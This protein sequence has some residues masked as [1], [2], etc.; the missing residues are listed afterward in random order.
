MPTIWRLTILAFLFVPWTGCP[1][2]DDDDDDA[3]GAAPVISDVEAEVSEAVTM[4]VTVR[5]TT[6]VPSTGH[7]EF[8]VGDDLSLSTPAETGAATDHE[9]VLLGLPADADASYRVVAEADGA[10]AEGE[11]STITTGPLPPELP[12][13]T[14]TGSGHDG[15]MAVPLLGSVSAATIL[16]ADGRIVWFRLYEGELDL[17]RVRLSHDGSSVLFNAADVSD[18]PSAET[19]IVRVALDG[20]SVTGVTIPWLAHDFVELPD[21]TLTAIAL[22][23]REV[24]GEDVRGDKLVEVAPDGTQTEI[25][26]TF[27]CWDPAEV[28]GTDPESGWTWTNAIDYDETGDDYY[29][30]IRNLSSIVKVDRATGACEWA[31]GGAAATLEMVGDSSGFLHQHQFQVLGDSVLVFDNDGGPGLASRAIEYELDLDAGTAEQ[32]WSF[33]TDPPIY[34]FV[35][36]DVNRFDD[37]AT[38]ITWSVLGQIDR[39][40]AAGESVWRLNT[41]MGYALGFDTVYADLYASRW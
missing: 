35:L 7:V 21:G 2:D 33:T 12:N 20:S 24:D 17:F 29:V 6:D 30:G 25:W 22:D 36:G 34:S 15:Y 8:G 26:S 10:V 3:T 4:V 32:T 1:T 41:A 16:D 40:T 9:A 11:L 28:V 31:L 23:I 18:E 5:W 38:L 39:V 14:V 37:G 19:E 27:D 13:P